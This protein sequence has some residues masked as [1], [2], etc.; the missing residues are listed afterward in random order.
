MWM[1]VTRNH[2]EIKVV[3]HHIHSLLSKLWFPTFSHFTTGMIPTQFDVHGSSDGEETAPS[4]VRHPKERQR[5]EKIAEVIGSNKQ[6]RYKLTVS[7]E[8]VEFLDLSRSKNYGIWND[9]FYNLRICDMKLDVFWICGKLESTP[10]GLRQVDQER[11]S[12]LDKSKAILQP[13]AASRKQRA[14]VVF[15]WPLVKVQ[16]IPVL[17]D[18]FAGS[19]CFNPHELFAEM[20]IHVHRISWSF[21]HPLVV[22]CHVLEKL[23]VNLC[24]NSWDM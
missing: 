12:K 11:K 22:N 20:K 23:G 24:V 10:V 9:I 15:L 3:W 13:E 21:D 4:R 8:T 2:S 17:V 19:T 14:V 7:F 5:F 16:L 18:I 6:C 1:N